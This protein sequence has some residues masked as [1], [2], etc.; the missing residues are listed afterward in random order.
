MS[1][2]TTFG[3][4]IAPERPSTEVLKLVKLAERSNVEYAWIMDEDFM[5]EVYTTLSVLALN[6]QKIKLGPGV[7]NPHTRHPAITA[8]SIATLDEI[9]NGRAVLGMGFGGS[10]LTQPFQIRVERVVQTVREY[11]MI[12]RK[13][14]NGEKTTYK[15]PKF[16]LLN[17][18]LTFGPSHKIPIYVGTRGTYML[19][20]AGE[21][22]DGVLLAGVPL[23]FVPY[24]L[25]QLKIGAEKVKRNLEEIDVG[26]VI[27]LSMSE[28][29]NEA[30]KLVKPFVTF[31]VADA[32]PLM[33]EKVGLTE[34][35]AM[36]IRKA[37]SRGI[38]EA[39]KYV[40][41]EMVEL[42]SVTGTADMC[43]DKINKFIK[44]GVN[45]LAFSSPFGP[46]IDETFKFI[47]EIIRGQ[48]N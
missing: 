26:N 18:Q 10:L 43:V 3:I 37:L 25:E 44:A 6:T 22:A 1:Y 5:R 34:E 29:V 15:S 14:L 39:A 31:V 21:L 46:K 16:N 19:R 33:L 20:M 7:T 40:T 11:L 23:Q 13:L 36:P 28:N 32:T 9:S 35:D 17:A 30:I 8:L 27:T 42:L 4:M 45:Q 2:M 38:F 41:D 24:A 47:A 12:V 48:H